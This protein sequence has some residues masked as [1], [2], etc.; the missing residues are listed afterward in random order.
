MLALTLP[1]PPSVNDYYGRTGHHV[2]LKPKGKA[3]RRAVANALAQLDGRTFAPFQ[4]GALAVR[5][6]L[7][8]PERKRGGVDPDQDNGNKALLDALTHAGVW[9]DDRQIRAQLNEVA[10]SIEGGSVTLFVEKLEKT[11]ITFTFLN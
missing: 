7:N 8:P 6:I 4:A 2:Y 11:S 10:E 9:H 1:Y 3:Y 5:V